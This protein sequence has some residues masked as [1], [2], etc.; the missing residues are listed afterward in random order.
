MKC[1]ACTIWVL[2]GLMVMVSLDAVPD[3]PA[4]NA[5]TVN[6]TAL[7]CVKQGGSCEPR[8][9]WD[10]HCTSLPRR[11]HCIRFTDPYEPNRPSDSIA[12]TGHAADP[13]PPAA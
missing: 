2:V 5:H 7:I 6:V 11:V 1:V 10:S 9:D 4:V 12:L 8:V 13:S 3:P